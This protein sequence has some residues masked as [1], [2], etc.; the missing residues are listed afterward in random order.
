MDVCLGGWVRLAVLLC[1]MG[2][3]T[4]T[5]FLCKS[6]VVASSCCRACP[7]CLPTSA[8]A[9]RRVHGLAPVVGRRRLPGR[10]CHDAA[11]RRQPAKGKAQG[12]VR[13]AARKLSQRAECG[14]RARLG[15]CPCPLYTRTGIILLCWQS[16]LPF[17]PPS[18]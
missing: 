1:C 5:Y 7:P 8:T 2:R 17:G 13:R 16:L 3:L 14:T 11:H 15:L 4:G 10:H 6:S 18:C 9:P 12:T